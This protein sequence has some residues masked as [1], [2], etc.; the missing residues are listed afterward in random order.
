MRL[1]ASLSTDAVCIFV[2]WLCT[3]RTSSQ[4]VDDLLIKRTHLFRWG[5]WRGSRAC[6]SYEINPFSSHPR[7]TTN[8]RT[9]GT[10]AALKLSATLFGRT[11]SAEILHCLSIPLWTAAVVPSRQAHQADFGAWTESDLITAAM[12]NEHHPEFETSKDSVFS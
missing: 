2:V 4:R 10:T 9:H 3:P 7:S 1:H 6:F 5:I 12:Q 11:H 8:T